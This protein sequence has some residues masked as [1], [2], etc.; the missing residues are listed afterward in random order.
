VKRICVFCG[1]SPGRHAQYS[2]AAIH[3]GETIARRGMGL[4]YGGGSV[5]LMGV[6]ANSVLRAG[7]Q[8]IGVIPKSLAT[9]EVAHFDLE[10]LR[11][12]ESMHERK[13]MMADLADGFIAL[14]GGMGTLEELCEILTWGQLGM[15]TKPCGV[16]NVDGYFD[17]FLEFL[18]HAVT[19]QFLKPKHRALLLVDQDPDRLLDAFGTYQPP[20]VAKW[21]DRGE[22]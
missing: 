10:D 6:V 8:V 20:K 2:E 15:H 13:A 18:E 5:G 12:V 19:E 14:P 16:L 3:L 7:G 22:T 17:L 11:V 9:K 1:S 21:I 4:I